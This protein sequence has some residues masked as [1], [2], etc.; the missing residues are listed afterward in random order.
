MFGC[1]I[2]FDAAQ[3]EIAFDDR[4]L[5]TQMKHANDLFFAIFRQQVERAL[6]RLPAV[7]RTSDVVRTTVRNPLAG[8]SCTLAGT[9]RAI[10]VSTRTMQRRLRNEGTSFAEVVDGLR[11]EMAVAYLDRGVAIPEVASLLGYADTT[12]FHRAFHQIGRAHV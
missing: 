4:A 7:T 2:E 5:D 12:A 10:G 6:A 11:R 3:T 8:G 9:A 1:P